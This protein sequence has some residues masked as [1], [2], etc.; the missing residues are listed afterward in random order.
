MSDLQYVAL[1]SPIF[2]FFFLNDPH[3]VQFLSGKTL[4]VSG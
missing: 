2:F 3:A 1:E 4:F